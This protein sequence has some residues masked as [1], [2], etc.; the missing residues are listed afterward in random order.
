M[1]KL[2]HGSLPPAC[3]LLAIFLMAG[4]Q[5][6][7]ANDLADVY[8]MAK[9]YDADILAAESRYNVEAQAKPIARANMLPHASITANTSDVRQK[10]RGETFGITGRDVDF[11]EH[12]YRLNV[13]QSLYHHGFYTQLRQAKNSVAKAKIDLDAAHQDLMI[14]TARAYF[15]VLAAQDTLTFQ[16]S[17]KEAIERQLKQ[18][19]RHFEVGLTAITDVKEAQASYDLAVAKEIEAQNALEISRDALELITSQ[20]LDNLHPLSDRM[21]LASPEPED[22][23]DWVHKALDQNLVLLSSEY[24]TRIAKQEIKLRQSY[25]LPTLDI[26]ASHSDADTGGL[27]GSRELEETRIGLELNIPLVEGGRTYYETKKARYNA[28]L[29]HNRHEKVRRE[30]IRSTRDAYLN[31]IADISLVK[32]RARTLESTQAAAH[33]AE[34]GFQVGTRTSVDVLLALKDTFQARR[35]YSRARYDYI[36]HTLELK[37]AAGTLS[38]D[39]LLKI[40]N[41]LN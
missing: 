26:V 29:A 21:E 12:S 41:W 34:A 3:F 28:E 13:R 4:H 31:V 36:L 35:N 9:R 30:T 6:A 24:Q 40:N 23:E 33:A 5:V 8:A 25:H 17:E 7:R 20:R 39:D 38:I 16:K 27:T 15:N 10:T 22:V 11:N 18:A 14:R 1:P 32:A 37:Q 2:T 19:Q